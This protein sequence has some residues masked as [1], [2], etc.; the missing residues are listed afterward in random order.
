MRIWL[1]QLSISTDVLFTSAVVSFSSGEI[2]VLVF[3]RSANPNLLSD[4]RSEVI[5]IR[6][7]QTKNFLI[8]CP[9]FLYDL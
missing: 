7:K 8:F 6:G 3:L 5:R 1:E 2:G 4:Q 9:N